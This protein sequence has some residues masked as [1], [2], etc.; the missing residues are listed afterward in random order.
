MNWKFCKET[1]MYYRGT[2]RAHISFCLRVGRQIQAV[3][4]EAHRER[5][6]RAMSKDSV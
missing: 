1:K 6:D 2:K 3:Y 5:V 4:D